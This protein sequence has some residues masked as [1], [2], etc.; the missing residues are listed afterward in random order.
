MGAGEK[1][2]RGEERRGAGRVGMVRHGAVRRGRLTEPERRDGRLQRFLVALLDLRLSL[3]AARVLVLYELGVP[4]ALFERLGLLLWEEK[5]QLLAP[6]VRDCVPREQ[7]RT[8][9]SI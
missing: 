7:L 1:R 8:I 6:G 2:P 5:G 9:V 3:A 4:P